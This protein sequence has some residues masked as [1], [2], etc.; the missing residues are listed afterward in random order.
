MQA[1]SA[2]EELAPL[3]HERD[4]CYRGARHSRGK[5]GKSIE[6]LF[7]RAVEKVKAP[8]R[9]KAGRILDVAPDT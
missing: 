3:I 5:A 4:Q 6:Y 8:Q 1:N 2:L 9:G 7:S